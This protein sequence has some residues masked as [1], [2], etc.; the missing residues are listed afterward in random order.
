MIW[1]NRWNSDVSHG[2]SFN[3][4]FCRSLL[5]TWKASYVSGPTTWCFQKLEPVPASQKAAPTHL[6]KI[7]CSEYRYKYE[8]I[9]TYL[10]CVCKF[11]NNSENKKKL[12]VPKNGDLQSFLPKKTAE[13]FIKLPPPK[14]DKSS[15]CSTT[16]RYHLQPQL[17]PTKTSSSHLSSTKKNSPH[18]SGLSNKKPAFFFNWAGRASPWA[19]PMEWL[20][21]CEDGFCWCKCQAPLGPWG[22]LESE[23]LPCAKLANGSETSVPKEKGY[24]WFEENYSPESFRWRE[25]I[26][27]LYKYIYI[28]MMCF[29]WGGVKLLVTEICQQLKYSKSQLTT[30]TE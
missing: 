30:G 12:K 3:C 27:Y 17:K 21:E 1:N 8:Q 23:H 28:W 19:V 6:K 5:P 16:N 22:L 15:P 20:Q 25:N 2:A 11:V 29:F 24:I 18:M 7:K 26:F 4:P 14:V 9:Y 13:C 10:M